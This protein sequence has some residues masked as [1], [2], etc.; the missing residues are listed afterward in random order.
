MPTPAE[1]D[2]TSE[3]DTDRV[4]ERRMTR[5]HGRDVDDAAERSSGFDLDEEDDEQDAE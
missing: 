5:R 4:G 3:R 2:P 1:S